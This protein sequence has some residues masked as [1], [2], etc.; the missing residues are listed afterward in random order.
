MEKAGPQR[1]YQAA[2]VRM[3]DRWL[4]MLKPLLQDIKGQ[5]RDARRPYWR[6]TS[7][8]DRQ[9]RWVEE[10]GRQKGSVCS[11]PGCSLPQPSA[12]YFIYGRPESSPATGGPSAFQ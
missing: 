2:G 10:G 4:G 8:A 11:R 5:L 9:Q 7:E 12:R 6:R 3:E 1:G